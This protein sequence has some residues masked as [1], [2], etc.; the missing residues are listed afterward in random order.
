M[1]RQAGTQLYNVKLNQLS[2][3]ELIGRNTRPGMLERSVEACS[4]V[5][6]TEML[7]YLHRISGMALRQHFAL[8]LHA[9]KITNRILELL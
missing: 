3:N 2:D 5:S 9:N 6:L 1:H 7:D 8:Y 4:T